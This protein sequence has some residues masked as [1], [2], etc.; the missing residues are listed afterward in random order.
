[1]SGGLF[2]NPQQCPLLTLGTH[3]HQNFQSQPPMIDKTCFVAAFIISLPH[4]A[5]AQDASP[6]PEPT[7]IVVEA[8]DMTGV[9]QDKFGTGA[10]WQVGRWGYDLYQN[11][12]FGGVWA[13]RLKTAMTDATSTH[14]EAYSD[15]TVPTDG[16]YKIWAKYEAPPYFNYAFGLRISSLDTKKVAFDKT[17]GLNASAKQYSFND[18][19]QTG[20]LYWNWGIDHDAAEGY[21]AKLAKGRYRVTLYKTA[22]PAPSAARSVDAI[23]ITSDLSPISSPR[24]PRYPLLDELRRANHVYFRFRNLSDKAG[25]VSWN[26]WNH[27]YEDFYTPLYKELVK[28]YDANGKE[29]S[30]PEKNN[31]NWPEPV[32][33]N[34]ASVWYDLGPTMNVESTSPFTV[35]MLPEG[36]AA[37]DASLPVSV[38][39]AL[40]PDAKKIVKSL[41]LGA[42]ETELTFL[43][44]PDIYRPE[45]AKWTKKLVDVYNDVTAQLN[46]EPRL[47]PIPQKIKIYATTGGPN[48]YVADGWGLEPAQN[49]R[50]A[51]GLN[52]IE[53]GTTNKAYLD[54]IA[55]WWQAHK[56]PLQTRSMSYQHSQN[57]QE[58]AE[59]MKKNDIEKYFY[60]LSFGDEIGL[61][62]VDTTDAAVLSEFHKYLEA[63]NETPKTLGLA[64]WDQV[65]PLPSLSAE[66]AVK[67]GVLPTAPTG[68]K[69]TEKLKRLYWY[70]TQFSNQKGIEKFVQKTIELKKLLGDQ[71]ETSANLGGMHPFFW[72]NQ[73]PF[74]E[75]FKHHAMSLAWSEDYTYTQPEAT[76]LVVDFESSYL[77]K[78]TTYN[79]QRMMYYC[80]P[81][82]PGNSPELL[83]NNAVMLWANNIKDLDWFV[84][85]PDA[86]STEN[87]IAYRGGMPMWK[88]LRTVSGMAGLIEDDL[89]P[90][91][92]VST[93]VAMLLSESSDIWELNGKSQGAVEPGSEESNITQEERKNL[94]YALRHA[95]YR[96]DFVTEDDVNAGLLDKYKVLYVSGQN[97]QH[98][99]A[100]KIKSWVNGG[101]TI[102]ATA[103]AARKDEFDAPTTALNE[104][105]GRGA[106]KSYDRYKGPLRAKIELLF[107]KPLDTVAVGTQSFDALASKE[108][109]AV[110]P[111]AQVLATYGSDKSPAWITNKFGKGTAYYI[112]ALPGEAFIQKALPVIPAGKGGSEESPA[113]HEPMNFDEAARETILR[114]LRDAQVMPDTST[115]QNGVIMGRL[116]SAR[117]TVL[118]IA[119]LAQ[120]REGTLKNLQVT[121]TG[122]AKKP[123]KVWSCFHQNGIPFEYDNGKLT[124]TLPTLQTADVVII[125]AQ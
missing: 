25:T 72:M 2:Q 48:N 79:D 55:T 24:Y 14:A 63:H 103:G 88:M 29:L 41:E 28:Y 106:Q 93:P 30:T 21:E 114:P 35:K 16:T 108:T 46:A 56:A 77:R 62:P 37:T 17:Y 122:I 92:P 80:M 23:L 70:S 105:L 102:Y 59:L 117:S 116:A 22:N 86:W 99:A 95:G 96:V 53:R 58:I 11:M 39:I 119:N 107:L 12:V 113:F 111:K 85:S 9:A 6:A 110:S 67:I 10:G 27:R 60:Y 73:A 49:F 20:S 19:L 66:V 120:Q 115:P 87:Y 82:W 69:P 38:D 104:V 1:V 65:K 5:R 83:L 15:I 31:G 100:A 32:A 33:A 52:T 101:G 8:E 68:D 57:P 51:L 54:K 26:H 118:P 109:F 13:S 40:A 18:K 7:R 90:A 124:L 94:W 123:T 42:G 3:N 36:G 121:M 97:L 45:G 89:M 78:G 34:G 61:P 71:A 75:A 76:R 74:I 98:D 84:A 91:R 43:V 81:H 50:L 125:A 4:I 64:S 112:G 44:Q 47:G